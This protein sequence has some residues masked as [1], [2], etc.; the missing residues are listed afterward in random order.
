MKVSDFIFQ[1]PRGRDP[2]FQGICR[3]RVFVVGRGQTV[4]MLTDLGHQNVGPSVT[5]AAES[6]MSALVKRGHVPPKCEFIEHYERTTI[7]EAMFHTLSISPAG[8]PKWQELQPMEVVNV[9]GCAANELNSETL[10]DGRL[11]AEIGRLKQSLSPNEDLPRSESTNVILRRLEIEDSMVSKAELQAVVQSGATEREM[12]RLLHR[13]L[14]LLGEVYANPRDEYI[15]F[16]EF[17]V[18]DGLVDFV[19]FTG[20]SRMDVFLI[21]VKG[22]GFNLI[23]RNHYS[24]FSA[25]VNEAAGQIRNRYRVIYN[26]YGEYRRAFHRVRAQAEKGKSVY[27][28]FLGP[29]TPLEVSPQKDVDVHGVVIGGRMRNDIS[30]SRKRHDFESHFTPHIMVESWDS[31][32]NKLQRG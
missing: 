22:A 31:W 25:R 23:N 9:L 7:S 10:D 11:V 27:G 1:Y 32:L 13:D 17:P 12:L 26:A 3:V 30:E 16:S 15:C 14:S 29:D 24:E 6:I 28:A 21:E 20:R 19:V 5:N 2:S 18:G 8:E 4:A